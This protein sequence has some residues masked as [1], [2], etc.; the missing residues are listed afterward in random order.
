MNLPMHVF[1]INSWGWFKITKNCLLIVYNST[2]ELYSRPD[3]IS[4]SV[5]PASFIHIQSESHG[6]HIIYNK[7]VSKIKRQ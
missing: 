7:Y 5:T 3:G 6:K 2:T 4:V 1:T